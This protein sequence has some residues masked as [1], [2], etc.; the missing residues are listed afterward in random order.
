MKKTKFNKNKIFKFSKTRTNTP[1]LISK[2]TKNDV[3]REGISKVTA[4]KRIKKLEKLYI[5]SRQ[6]YLN[7]FKDCPEALVYTDIDGI[8]LTANR[9]F[10]EL[11]GF[12]EEELRDNSII[13][14]LKPEERKYF[15]YDNKGYFETSIISKN[16][17]WIE[18][19][20]RRTINQVDNRLAGIIYSFQEISLLQR[21]RRII[22]V[23]YYISQLANADIPVKELFPLI[24]E[25]LGRIINTTNFYI[26]LTD[27]EQKEINFP[28]Y[29]D[30]AA[31]D[32]ETFINRYCTSQSIFHYVLKIGKPVL[33]DFQRYRKMLSYGYIE[34]WDVM[35]NTHIWLAVPLKA[36]E[37]VIGVI[38]L[39]SYNN[40]RLYRERDIDL[41]EFVS[42][43]VSSAIYKEE[44]KVK[45]T[46]M[47]HDLE[48]VNS[49]K[50]S[51]D[52]DG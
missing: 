27:S 29:T 20:V 42:Q 21:D 23:L 22:K 19:A 3:K 31:G 30:E 10:E 15:E 9:Y 47:K 14:C 35:T 5:Q 7:L 26:A 52:L 16:N 36:D 17:Y 34:S 4:D 46:K 2:V 8:V 33:M 32:D 48:Q 49:N 12:K 43:Q 1:E 13:Y 18:V 11:T 37:K 41:L 25:Q 40:A 6:E 38:A 24:H 45:I 50:G 28:Y 51:L 39:Q 44:L